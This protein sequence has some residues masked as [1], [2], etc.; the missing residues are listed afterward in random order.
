MPMPEPP[1]SLVDAIKEH[2]AI[3]I[4][5]SGLSLPQAPTW[6][7]L[8]QRLIAKAE[9]LRVAPQATLATAL[10][11][12]EKDH[13]LNA[14]TLLAHCLMPRELHRAIRD[15][16]EYTQDI[17][18]CNAADLSAAMNG[19]TVPFIVRTLGSPVRRSA[20]P[21]DAQKILMCLN[22]QAVFT[23]NY[24]NLL[25][26]ASGGANV[27]WFTHKN[28]NARTS[29]TPVNSCF[30]L[31]ITTTSTTRGRSATLPTCYP[32]FPGYGSGSVMA[33]SM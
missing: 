6:S 18:S 24:D 32:F 14:A 17:E 22:L 12:L 1:Q 26:E 23:T 30:L 20:G 3:A 5:G 19:S 31:R 13:H 33:I 2:R 11:A 21:T 27:N 9:L 15:V 16:F 8:L 25:E 29:V 28:F 7:H 4:V 10:D